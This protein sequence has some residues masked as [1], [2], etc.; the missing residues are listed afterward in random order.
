MVPNQMLIRQLVDVS[1]DIDTNICA[2]QSR[3][4]RMQRVAVRGQKESI[5]ISSPGNGRTTMKRAYAADFVF[6]ESSS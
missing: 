5:R 3:R 6:W 2:L 4:D 1:K